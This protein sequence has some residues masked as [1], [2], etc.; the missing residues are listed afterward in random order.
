LKISQAFT[1]DSEIHNDHALIEKNLRKNKEPRREWLLS[2]LLTLP[3]LTLVENFE[4]DGS[5]S[6]D[7][8]GRLRPIIYSMA[9]KYAR[10]LLRGFKG[11][12]DNLGEQVH[13]VLGKMDSEIS[14]RVFKIIPADAFA[15]HNRGGF[16]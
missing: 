4:T 3:A 8:N 1:H 5:E 12:L 14:S 6:Q 15:N 10:D 16:D 9:H 11:D 13:L 7:L 2:T